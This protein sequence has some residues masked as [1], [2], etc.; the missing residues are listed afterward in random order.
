MLQPSNKCYKRIYNDTTA[1]VNGNGVESIDDLAGPV[2]TD[3][4]GNEFRNITK[5]YVRVG[6]FHT[7][8]NPDIKGGYRGN[9]DYIRHSCIPITGTPSVTP[10]HVG[11]LVGNPCANDSGDS[12]SSN[13][14]PDSCSIFEPDAAAWSRKS[15]DRVKAPTTN[16]QGT[17]VSAPAAAEGRT[18]GY[19]DTMSG[20]WVTEP[21]SNDSCD[22]ITIN[23]GL[24]AVNAGDLTFTYDNGDTIALIE[25]QNYHLQSESNTIILVPEDHPLVPSS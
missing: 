13:I 8:T 22:P 25:G 9:Q 16:S 5:K 1:G 23:F 7:P 3:V 10:P 19:F 21:Y 11:N 17:I 14:S 20:A 15:I 6:T 2:Q 18:V 4:F 24:I 12:V